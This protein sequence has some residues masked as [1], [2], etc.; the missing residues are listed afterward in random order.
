MKCPSDAKENVGQ[1]LDYCAHKLDPETAAV[2]EAHLAGCT[3]CREFTDNQRTVW[4]ALDAWEAEPVSADFNRRLYARIDREV[5]WWQALLRPLRPMAMRW[6]VAASAAGVLVVLAAG[7]LINRPGAIPPATHDTA[8]VES[9]QPEQ[10]E[11]ALDAMDMLA[12]FDHQVNAGNAAK[13]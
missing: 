7:L 3:A 10:V 9:V 2:L 1:L 5:P 12:E 8:Q 11:H 13:M 4:E 6:N